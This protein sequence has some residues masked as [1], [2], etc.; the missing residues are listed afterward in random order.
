MPPLSFTDAQLDQVLSGA[1]PLSDSDHAAYLQTV[2]DLLHGVAEPGDRDVHRAV[3]EAQRKF[4]TPP[5]DTA[6]PPMQLKKIAR[7]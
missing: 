1:A 5:V 7:R 6:H 2:A 4:W 3:R